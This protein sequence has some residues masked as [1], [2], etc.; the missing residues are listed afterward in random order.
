MEHLKNDTAQYVQISRALPNA[1]EPFD[2]VLLPFG[3]VLCGYICLYEIL[4]H[5][6][7]DQR[8]AP[9]HRV[10]QFLE[11]LYSLVAKII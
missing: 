10:D 1:L 2:A 5:R 9:G 11:S 3:E 6:L 7:S 8:V 4:D